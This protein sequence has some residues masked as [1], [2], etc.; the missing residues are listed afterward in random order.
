MNFS[1]RCRLGCEESVKPLQEIAEHWAK[2]W[3]HIPAVE[4]K[5]IDGLLMDWRKQVREAKAKALKGAAK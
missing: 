1:V 4:L 5:K 3:L 2:H